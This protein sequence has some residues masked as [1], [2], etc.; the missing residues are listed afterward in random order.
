[1]LTSPHPSLLGSSNFPKMTC[2]CFLNVALTA[3]AYRRNGEFV[4][5]LCF[6]YISFRGVRVEI[7]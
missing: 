3:F 4:V 7:L 5:L 2:V 1:M 6:L